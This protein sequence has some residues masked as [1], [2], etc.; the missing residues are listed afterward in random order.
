MD[1]GRVNPGL[2][3]PEREGMSLGI[4]PDWG[5]AGLMVWGTDAGNPQRVSPGASFDSTGIGPG[6][7]HLKDRTGG[8]WLRLHREDGTARLELLEPESGEVTLD[9]IERVRRTPQRRP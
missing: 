2:D 5:A 1:N 4:I 6:G 9:V 3:F 8:K 7:L